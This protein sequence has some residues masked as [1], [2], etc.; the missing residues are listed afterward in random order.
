MLLFLNYYRFAELI[1]GARNAYV[2][3]DTQ[4]TW[5]WDKTRQNLTKLRFK[6]RYLSDQLNFKHLQ[7]K[8]VTFNRVRVLWVSYTIPTTPFFIHSTP[9]TWL[10]SYFQALQFPAILI[11]SWFHEHNYRTKQ[12]QKTMKFQKLSV[13]CVFSLLLFR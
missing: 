12:Q 9:I 1:F 3:R 8:S 5:F 4:L 6:N 13:W 11:W 2:R 7:L 10:K